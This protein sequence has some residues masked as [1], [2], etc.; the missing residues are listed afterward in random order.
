MSNIKRISIDKIELDDPRYVSF[1]QK[2]SGKN[3]YLANKEFINW[4]KTNPSFQTYAVISENNEIESIIQTSR[5]SGLNN[6]EQDV[7]FNFK[8]SANK[9]YGFSIIGMMKNSESFLIPAVSGPLA[10]I[11]ELIGGE[12]HNLYWYQK[13]LLPKPNKLFL[14]SLFGL[15]I[16]INESSNNISLTNN[17]SDE[18]IREILKTNPIFDKD[19]LKWRL[20]SKRNERVIFGYHKISGSFIISSFGKRKRVPVIRVFAAY[21]DIRILESILRSVLELAKKIGIPLALITL[22]KEHNEYL[23]DKLNLKLYRNKV[24][25]YSKN[26]NQ[27]KNKCLT[28]LY[29]D[30]GLEEQ[31]S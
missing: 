4:A 25:T 12:S 15:P 9:K 23:C 14:S 26:F 3:T 2:T 22:E 16:R 30:L 20:G 19:Y 24:M 8:S 11:Y 1:V 7:F 21:G 17:I 13:K 31:W 29:G 5:F 10:K 28:M 6:L 27:G 18:V